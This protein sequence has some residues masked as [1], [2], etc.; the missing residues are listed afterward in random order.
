MLE[1]QEEIIDKISEV[2]YLI[3]KGKRPQ[4]IVLPEGFP[5]NEMKQAVSFINKFLGEYNALADL[6]QALS[7]GEIEFKAPRGNSQLFGAMKNLQGNLRNLTWT[8]QRIATGDFSQK[9]SFMG[10]FSEAFNSMTRQLEKNINEREAAA[11]SLETKV[12][13]LAKARRAMINIL[14]DLDVAKKAAEAA[15]Q[16][17]ADFLAN[18]SHEIRTPMNAIIGFSNLALKTNLEPKQKDYVRKIEQSGKH[19]LGIIN[20][21]LDFSKVEA[22]KLDIE[23]AD[24]ELEKVMENVSNLISD[25]TA[26]KGLALKFE[27]D[28][29]APNFLIGDPLR[30]GQILINYSNNAVKFTDQGEIIISVRLLEETETDVLMR[31][32]VRDTGIGLTE[33]QMGKLFQSFQ[34]ADTST[35]RK[36]GGTGLGLAISK[37]LAN[38]MGGDV[39]VESEHGQGS[40]FWF[41]ASLGKGTAKEREEGDQGAALMEKLA[42][43]KGALILL[44]ED[45]EF[46]QQIAMELLSDAGFKIEV[47]ENGQQALEK[48]DKQTY[49]IVLMDMQ[50]PVMDG[51]TATKEIRK[52]SRFAEL[53]VVAMTANVMAAEVEKCYQAGMND[54]VGKPIEPEDLFGKLLKWIK[55]REFGSAAEPLSPVQT[56]PE[57]QPAPPGKQDDLADVPGLD[58]DLGLKRFMGKKAFYLD[59][60]RKYAEKQIEIP[61]QIRQTLAANDPGTAERLAHTIKGVSGNIGATGVQAIAAELEHSIKHNNP[62]EQTSEILERFGQ[63]LAELIGHLS[64][65]LGIKEKVEE[66][67]A[68]APVDPARIKPILLK[69]SQY[70][71]DN[72]SEVVDYLETAGAELKGAVSREAYKKLEDLIGSY[73]FEGALECL[74]EIGELLDITI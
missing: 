39:G 41:T 57:S 59:M 13:D 2:F 61:D 17:K 5:D 62:P 66:E 32:A 42:A 31:F 74:K 43:L 14:N 19:L 9:V 29:Q 53:P 51:V 56:D 48:L 44:V 7:K 10:D 3:M 40:T 60:L 1:V 21:I 22:G 4:A 23:Q 15:S 25:K 68:T 36:Y 72:D 46:N 6:M 35:S 27:I 30:L 52:D 67:I 26:S 12:S 20:D 73:D 47:A 58:T 33:E 28:P 63:A 50:M 18:M 55:P 54:H 8:T 11:R 64:Q 45:N 71:Q 65:A 24:F 70:L 16:A 37:K 49:D 69:V 38:L 34:Q